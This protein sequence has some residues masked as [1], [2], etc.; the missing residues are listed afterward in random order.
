[1]TAKRHSESASGVRDG[2]SRT[3][4]TS[5][6]AGD[7]RTSGSSRVGHEQVVA[8][9]RSRLLAAAVDVV[10]EFGWD[11]ASIGRITQRAGVSRRTFYEQF[12]NRDECLVA[13]LENAAA[14]IEAEIAAANLA[15]LPWRERVRRGLWVILCLLDREMVLARVCLVESRRSGGTALDCR[16]RIVERLVRI[17]D[18]GRG[19]GSR[20]R[21][22][23]ELTAHGVV[24]GVFEVLYSQLMKDD[25][26]PLSDLLGELT[27]MVVLP[28]MGVAAA[29]REQSKPAPTVRSAERTG[30]DVVAGDAAGRD[31]LARLPMRLTYRTANVLQVLEERPG[32]SNRE[33]ADLVGISD[34]GQ[35]SKLLTRLARLGLLKNVSVVGERNEWELTPTGGRVTCSIK[36]YVQQGTGHVARGEVEHAF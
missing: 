6:A 33:V 36:S 12:E 27:G 11:G 7:P 8:M 9:Q 24:G 28:Y 35:I 14:L 16:Q 5:Q 20:G 4:R 25:A 13:V 1:M 10:A 21:D 19:E 18:Q 15:A 22:V 34:Q 30:R 2:S 17:V 3:S 26:K 23:T 29:Q 31:L 32:R